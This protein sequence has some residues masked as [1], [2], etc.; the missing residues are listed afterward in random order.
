MRTVCAGASSSSESLRVNAFS[1][2]CDS[3]V[4]LTTRT[5]D[6]SSVISSL[7]SAT[8]VSKSSSSTSSNSTSSP[9]IFVTTFFPD[10]STL[11]G[12]FPGIDGAVAPACAAFIASSSALVGKR[13]G[14]LGFCAS[15]SRA[16]FIASSSALV[17]KR[18]GPVPFF[19]AVFLAGDFLAETE[20]FFPEFFFAATLFFLLF[21]SARV[22]ATK[23]PLLFW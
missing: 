11:D 16:A 14:P 10:A 23:H 21:L 2:F 1:S 12:A 20:T 8:R 5:S 19:T 6:F 17:G 22:T 18:R 4:R 13:R 9:S 3:S 15:I 7:V